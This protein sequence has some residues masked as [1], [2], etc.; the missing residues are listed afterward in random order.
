MALPKAN[1]LKSRKDFQ[2]V[3]REGIR[4]H[5][6]YLTL[7][8]LKPLCSTKPSLETVT[9][10]TQATESLRL[11]STRI[12]ISI[13]TK[14]SKRAVVR[15]RIKRQITAVLSN[16]LP[17]LSPGWRLVFIVK[18]T[19]TESKCASPQFLQEL[20]QLLAQAEVFDGNS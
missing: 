3:F 6:S 13:S 11:A 14:V 16:L 18:P 19:A 12:G 4:R 15:N 10:T 5:G 9:Q 17:K 1:R 2:A 7:R 8:A 20:E